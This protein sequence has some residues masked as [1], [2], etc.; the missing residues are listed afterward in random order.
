MRS[1]D[2]ELKNFLDNGLDYLQSKGYVEAAV[3]KYNASYWYK[4]DVQY[5]EV[6]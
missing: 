4:A 3:K 5:V 6:K 1:D 2:Q